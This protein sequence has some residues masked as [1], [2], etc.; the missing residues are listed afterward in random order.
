MQQSGR[1]VGFIGLDLLLF[2]CFFFFFQAL[3][4]SGP[5][6]IKQVALRGSAKHE[7]RL[8]YELE[9]HASSRGEGVAEFVEAVRGADSLF[10]VM[11]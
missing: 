8:R 5:V 1:L 9:A 10:V 11:E 3:S 2:V 4:A 7:D 6:A